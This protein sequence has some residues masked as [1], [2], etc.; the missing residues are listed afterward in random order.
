MTPRLLFVSRPSHE[1]EAAIPIRSFPLVLLFFFPTFLPF[2]QP[3]LP[4]PLPSS[5]TPPAR[6]A[7]PA[8]A[9]VSS[10]PKRQA[11]FFRP[12]PF[13]H[14]FF[15]FFRFQPCSANVRVSG[16]F[17][18]RSPPFPNTGCRRSRQPSRGRFQAD[19]KVD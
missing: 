11:A 10:G 1:D 4:R 3:F 2:T 17:V 14:L 6:T 12:F 16:F 7:P 5:F 19:P 8:H 15:N 13:S 18:R 9:P